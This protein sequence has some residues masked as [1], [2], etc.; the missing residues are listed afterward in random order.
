MNFVLR[1]VFTLLAVASA[2]TCIF[3]FIYFSWWGFIP[4]AGVIVFGGLMYFFS[5]RDK[6]D[7]VVERQEN[8]TGDFITGP[9]HKKTAEETAAEAADADT[10]EAN[11]QNGESKDKAKSKSSKKK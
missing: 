7:E 5:N 4:L 1:I 10:H 6:K 11:L 8:R 2:A 3:I 9:V